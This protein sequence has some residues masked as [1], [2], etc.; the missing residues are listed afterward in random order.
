M[1]QRYRLAVLAE[2]VW[3]PVRYGDVFGM[4]E[5]WLAAAPDAQPIELMIALLDAVAPP[6]RLELEVLEP[7]GLDAE[8]GQVFP[9]GEFERE[10]LTSWLREHAPLLESDA[11]LAVIVHGS[12][13]ERIVYDEHNRLLLNGP[14]ESYEQLLMARG[15][16]PGDPSV[17]FPHIHQY[18]ADLTDQIGALF[19]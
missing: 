5:R 19:A 14:I 11:R 3:K 16:M 18:R 4:E 12:H 2:G 7:E 17:P 1:D 6:Y 15:I 10:T 13:H 9:I 8:E